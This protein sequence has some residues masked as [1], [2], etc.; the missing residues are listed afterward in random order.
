MHSKLIKNIL[1]LSAASLALGGM[2]SVS[3]APP[4]N[5]TDSAGATVMSA[6]DCVRTSQWSPE[7][8]VDPAC[9]GY[10]E[11]VVAPAPAPTPPPPAPAPEF[12]TTT[13]SAET[14]FD[15]DSATLRAQGRETLR[16][17]A[18]TLT[19]ADVTYTSVLVEGHTCS[20]GPAAY[21]QGLSERRAQSV[22]DYLVGEG[23]RPDAV[24]MVGYGEER[25]TADNA[26]RE[27]RELN[28]RV[29]VTTDVRKRVQ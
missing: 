4:A 14:L 25:P 13:L 26:T 22:V 29:E 7:G 2:A 19:S 27:G 11:P 1:A 24:R 5:I 9:S 16:E 6:S 8:V 20:I 17:L 3:A 12:T 18:S 10:I 15:F 23:V 28:R 21:N